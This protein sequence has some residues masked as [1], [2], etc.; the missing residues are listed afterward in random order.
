MGRGRSPRGGTDDTARSGAPP[1]R[2]HASRRSVRSPRLRRR[3]SLDNSGTTRAVSVRSPPGSRARRGPERAASRLVRG[4]LG[5]RRG[6]KSRNDRVDV[7]R[8]ALESSGVRLASSS[9]RHVVRRGCPQHG[10]QA[11]ARQLAEPTLESV[12]VDRGLMVSWHDD[13]DPG[14][15]QRGREHADVEVRGANSP[16]LL[17]NPLNVEAP[18]EASL[19]RKPK[20]AVRRRRTCSAA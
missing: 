12:A 18:C 4:R 13:P 20:A 19:T 3:S 17:Y 9:N 7:G 1:S 5:C 16:P 2:R 11:S 8:N 10:Q 14:T 15:R 6:R